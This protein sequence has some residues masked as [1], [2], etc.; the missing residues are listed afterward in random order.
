MKIYDKAKSI[1]S[2]EARHE[3]VKDMIQVHLDYGPFIIGTVA[4][5]PRVGVKST[6]MKNVPEQLT[7]GWI[8]DWH[9]SYIATLNPE[10]FYLEE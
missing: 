10:Q 7:A 8:N 9:L 6:S 2:T 5:Y 1:P 4:G 3:L